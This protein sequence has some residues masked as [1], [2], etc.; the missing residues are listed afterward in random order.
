MQK[1]QWREVMDLDEKEDFFNGTTALKLIRD[2][3]GEE[4]IRTNAQIN[5]GDKYWDIDQRMVS[6]NI[7]K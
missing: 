2:F 1:Y 5:R 6:V 7:Q 3:F 4:Y